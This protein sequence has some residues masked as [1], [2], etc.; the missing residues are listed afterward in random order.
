MP[1]WTAHRALTL[2]AC[3]TA[4]PVAIVA[5]PL[6]FGAFLGGIVTTTWVNPDTDLKQRLGQFGTIIG[7]KAYQDVA[8]HRGGLRKRH[9]R[10]SIWQRMANSSHLPLMG[11]IPRWF[12]LMVP[13]T[14]LYLM[15]GGPVL[16]YVGPA[17]FFMLGMTY[18]DL[19]HVLADILVTNFKKWRD[20]KCSRYG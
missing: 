3:F 9:W 5:S 14:T 6:C 20:G 13:P 7:L 18:S 1:N 2:C 11:T 17:I 4:L 19:W 15:L 16:P 10:G 12:I 8:P